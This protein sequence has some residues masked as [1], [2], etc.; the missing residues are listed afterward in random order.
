MKKRRQMRNRHA[1]ATPPAIA[2]MCD[3]TGLLLV[4]GVEA[5]AGVG[6][7]GEGEG[8]DEDDDVAVADAMA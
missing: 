6:D 7:D 5:D 4:L 1:P 3:W 2:A 8:E